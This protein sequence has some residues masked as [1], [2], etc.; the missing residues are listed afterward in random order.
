MNLTTRNNDVFVVG[1]GVIGLSIAWRLSIEGRRVTILERDQIGKGSSWAG[2]GIL[3]PANLES[4][5]P[6]DLLRGLSHQ[7]FP[8]WSKELESA[9]GQDPGL[10]LCGGWYLADSPG[11]MAS[12]VGMADYWNRL[13]IEA[14]QIPM[15]EL[16]TRETILSE[17]SKKPESIGAWWVPNEYQLRPPWYLKSLRAACEN[18]NVTFHEQCSVRGVRE[19]NTTPQI[20]VNDHWHSCN[21]LVICSG[22]WIN[23]HT[24]NLALGKSVFPIRGQMLLLKTSRPLSTRIFNLGQ[25]YLVCRDDGH[26][27]VGSCEEE[28]GFLN[29]TT[30]EVQENLQ[31]FAVSLIPQLQNAQQK[32][33]WSGF[34]PMT[35]DGLPMIGRVPGSASTYVACGHFRSGLHLSPATAQIITDLLQNRKTTIP[36]APFRVGQQTNEQVSIR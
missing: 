11:E 34:R 33:S 21:Q 5:E 3:P 8:A 32:T 23:Q 16:S 35:L 17:W 36:I 27:L 22:A 20:N 14:H 4:T 28:V 9:T 18:Q 25:R 26:V 19:I 7:L 12:L 13:K 10:R 29:G 2:A 15:S 24:S 6:I 31:Q 1:G 30:D